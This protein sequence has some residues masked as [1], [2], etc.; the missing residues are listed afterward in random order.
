MTATMKATT[1]RAAARLDRCR[2]S[3]R[4]RFESRSSDGKAAGVAELAAD[5]DGGATKAEAR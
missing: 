1:Q 2:H 3:Q 5:F 4:G